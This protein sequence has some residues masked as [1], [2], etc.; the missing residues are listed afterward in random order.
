MSL[1]YGSWKMSAEKTR[2]RT[3]ARLCAYRTLAI[4]A[5]TRNAH[6][7]STETHACGHT[8]TT[9]THK[10]PKVTH[11]DKHARA[12]PKQTQTRAQAHQNLDFG[13][14]KAR[15]STYDVDSLS[16]LAAIRQRRKNEETRNR[17]HLSIV[18]KVRSRRFLGG[19]VW[20]RECAFPIVEFLARL[21][22]RARDP[23]IHDC[24]RGVWSSPLSLLVPESAGNSQP[25]KT[26][27]KKSSYN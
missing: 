27:V 19:A 4:N 23:N 11:T 10:P 17:T 20:W 14:K 9:R 3:Q 13:D 24:K 7:A 22:P 12:H 16:A 8:Y 6:S 25:V 2:A 18:D 5:Y 15:A 21:T 1:P 26:I